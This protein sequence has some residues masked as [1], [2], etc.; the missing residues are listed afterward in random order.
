MTVH[1]WDTARR[2]VVPFE[3]GPVVTMRVHD[4][5]T[6][7]RLLL[8][9][10][11]AFGEAYMDGKLTVGEDNSPKDRVLELANVAGPIVVNE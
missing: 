3:P 2:E 9:P 1:L 11:L 8:R 7:I 5:W 4:W 6:G 10:R